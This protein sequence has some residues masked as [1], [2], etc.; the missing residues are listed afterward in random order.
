MSKAVAYTY[1]VSSLPH[2][3]DKNLQLTN[4]LAYFLS[5]RRGRDKIFVKLAIDL[6]AN[7]F[8]NDQTDV[9]ANVYGDQVTA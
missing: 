8:G 6:Q 2:R 7:L 9:Q 1:G 4:A 3:P 5:R